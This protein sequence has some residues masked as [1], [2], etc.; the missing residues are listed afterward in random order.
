MNTNHILCRL[1]WPARV[2]LSILYGAITCLRNHIYNAGWGIRKAPCKVIS[3]GNIRVGGS[4]K[5]PY[6][7]ALVKKLQDDGFKVAVLSRGYGGHKK[8]DQLCVTDGVRVLM[9]AE[10]AGDEPVMM[11]EALPG[12]PIY[13]DPNRY[14]I[15]CLAYIEHQVD[16]CVLDD[17]F[18]HR[19]LFRDED[20]VL[21][22]VGSDPEA[23]HVM[24]W[25]YL[26]ESLAGLKRAD[27]IVLTK[28]N[29]MSA[30]QLNDVKL[31]LARWNSIATFDI[32]RIVAR[33]WRDG[34]TGQMYSVEHLQGKTCVL[35]SALA[36]PQ[37]LKSLI[38]D[39]G[40]IVKGEC[41]FADH[42][43]YTQDDLSKVRDLQQT[44]GAD[45]V[46]CTAKDAVKLPKS[47]PYMVLDIDCQMSDLQ[48]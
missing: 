12:V 7:I 46:I 16:L 20:I 11:A 22:D 39:L 42:H 13:V 8:P 4:G 43:L 41:L 5:T 35:V 47:M 33:Q 45:V 21:W 9:T 37:S 40:V 18:Q 15:A 29:W 32:S 30:S 3:V 2:L 6:V 27:R 25:G 38:E 48:R 10:E 44:L 26:R 24:P 19:R 34:L 1:L 23:S 14:K 17:G 31:S 28:T 36:Q